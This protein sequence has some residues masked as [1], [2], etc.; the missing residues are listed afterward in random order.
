MSQFSDA[1]K[2]LIKNKNTTV[3]RMSKEFALDWTTLQR[4]VSGKRLP[5]QGFVQRFCDSLQLTES[6]SREILEY[7]KMEQLGRNTYINRRHIRQF[8]QYL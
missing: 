2:A 5:N 1:C 4:M 6:E 3:Y 7:Y 8:C